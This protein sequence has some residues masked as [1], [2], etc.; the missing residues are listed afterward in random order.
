MGKAKVFIFG[1]LFLCIITDVSSSNVPT[2]MPVE[3]QTYHDNSNPL[4]YD[5]NYNDT[6]PMINNIH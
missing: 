5:Y 6:P 3:D 2:S 4:K 1:M